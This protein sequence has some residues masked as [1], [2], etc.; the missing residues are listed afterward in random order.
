MGT[1]YGERSG[2]T[3]F[4][5]GAERARSSKAAQRRSR[6]KNNAPG[7]HL[8]CK[9]IAHTYWICPHLLELSPVGAIGHEALHHRLDFSCQCGIE[10]AQVEGGEQGE[11]ALAEDRKST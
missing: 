1:T 7:A 11:D 4:K 10:G 6:L 3:A 8:C 9:Q 5:P 2:A